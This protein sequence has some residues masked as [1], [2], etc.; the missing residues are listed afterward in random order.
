MATT[1]APNPRASLLSGLR[2]GGV[3]STSGPTHNFPHSAAPGASFNV[4]RF[5]S[6]AYNNNNNGNSYYPDESDDLADMLAQN[7]YIQSAAPRMHQPPMTAAVDGINRF[8][9]QQYSRA[10]PNTIGMQQAAEAQRQA[11]QAQ[12]QAQAQQQALQMQMLQLE[13][14]RLQV[15]FSSC[16]ALPFGA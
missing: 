8:S 14:M 1:P 2:T 9:Q 11:Q 12:A 3:R 16:F 13:M 5:A 7:M 10:M 4:T 15:R 6:Q